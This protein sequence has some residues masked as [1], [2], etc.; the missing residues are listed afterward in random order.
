MTDRTGNIVKNTADSI[1][2]IK[3]ITFSLLRI[4]AKI[5]MH[6]RKENVKLGDKSEKALLGALIRN[7][8]KIPKKTKEKINEMRNSD[9]RLEHVTLESENVKEF[10]KILDT[11]NLDYFCLNSAKDNTSTIHFF[12]Q[13]SREIGNCFIELN[14]RD[15]EKAYNMLNEMT[16]SHTPYE[17]INREFVDTKP[18][19]IPL[20]KVNEISDKLKES[21]I[22]AIKIEDF[23]K[24]KNTFL[25]SFEVD[26]YN[27][28]KVNEII[29]EVIQKA[30]IEI[31]EK[32]E[33]Q[34]EKEYKEEEKEKEKEYK[35][36]EKNDEEIESDEMLTEAYLESL[37]SCLGSFED[38]L[39]IALG[40]KNE[41]I[42]NEQID[43]IPT[44][45]YIKQ[46][47]E[48]RLDKYKETQKN[49]PVKA[50]E[51]EK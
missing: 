8:N 29:N 43:E 47:G 6:A 36:E 21:G 42:E 16:V 2:A 44:L 34:Q 15:Q 45:A 25:Y 30:E 50:I 12:A 14:L 17:L 51:M 35:K 11:H 1:V 22:D 38:K 26:K 40:D 19:E 49:E 4:L 23:D 3:D 31:E 9:K 27:L 7:N 18:L 46:K 10:V 48:A 13:D 20:E 39:D 24:N 32:Q 28:E 33:K 5:L 37:E 41:L